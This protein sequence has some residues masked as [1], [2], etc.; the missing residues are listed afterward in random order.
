MGKSET[1]YV[2]LG[3]PSDQGQTSPAREQS[4]PMNL[5]R[6]WMFSFLEDGGVK[7]RV[8]ARLHLCSLGCGLNMRRRTKRISLR[9][10]IWD[11]LS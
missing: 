2:D 6:I 8:A 11:P 10:F 4:T 9:K 5:E 3:L 1:R 7:E